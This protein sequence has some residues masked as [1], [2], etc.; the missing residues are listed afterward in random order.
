MQM[1]FLYRIPPTKPRIQT[2]IK[3]HKT[4]YKAQQ[5][6]G[7]GHIIIA[8]FARKF[9]YDMPK[10]FVISKT[11]RLLCIQLKRRYFEYNDITTR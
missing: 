1:R 4:A 2:R 7:F 8:F 11:Q 6:N 10:I 3:H 9:C 5:T